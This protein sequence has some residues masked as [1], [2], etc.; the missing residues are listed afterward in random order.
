MNSV[1]H[2][3]TIWGSTI[4]PGS[5][6]KVFASACDDGILRLFDIRQSVSGILLNLFH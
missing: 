6:A 5:N 3:E 1:V 4:Q 2:L